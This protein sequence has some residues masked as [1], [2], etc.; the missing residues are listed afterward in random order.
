MNYKFKVF[1]HEPLVCL[2]NN[3]KTV[4][5]VC[6]RCA[7]KK[8]GACFF[9]SEKVSSVLSTKLSK[10][11]VAQ[12]LSF[13]ILGY[14]PDEDKPEDGHDHGEDDHVHSLL[15]IHLIQGKVKP[16][17][18]LALNAV[19]WKLP[20]ELLGQWENTIAIGNHCQEENPE[21][22]FEEFEIRLA[23]MYQSTIRILYKY[24]PAEKLVRC[25]VY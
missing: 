18:D 19:F 4:I 7:R 22:S 25:S 9:N 6:K 17:A 14:L 2:K 10:G 12:I 24:E 21:K 20:L 16:H 3:N 13:D 5:Q 15:G 8:I 1:V 23:I 11:T